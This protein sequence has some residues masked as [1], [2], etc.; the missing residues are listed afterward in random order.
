MTKLPFIV[1]GETVGRLTI[2]GLVARKEDLPDTTPLSYRYQANLTWCLCACG[3][4]VAYPLALLERG[5]Y[6]SCGCLKREMQASKA[7]AYQAKLAAIARKTQLTAQLRKLQKELVLHQIT[8][9]QAE[10][11]RLGPV[12]RGVVTELD[13]FKYVRIPKV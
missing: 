8:G 4:R 7:G 6:K 11:N 5:T 9:N 1:E 13:K 12:I 3:N 10:I 2:Q